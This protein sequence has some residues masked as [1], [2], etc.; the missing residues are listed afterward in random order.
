MM[1]RA[2]GPGW[3]GGR[4][5]RKGDVFR[6]SDTD[7]VGKWMQ[8]IPDPEAA[9]QAPPGFVV[10][11]RDTA[12]DRLLNELVSGDAAL[13]EDEDDEPEHVEPEGPGR[14]RIR[15][16]DQFVGEPEPNT[17]SEMGR[18]QAVLEKKHRKAH[19]IPDEDE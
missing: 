2:I 9:V 14:A 6:L 10:P 19:G 4:R 15:A 16:S 8:L 13:P 7:M 12:A 5:R 1:V 18:M 11:K 3:Y 17:L